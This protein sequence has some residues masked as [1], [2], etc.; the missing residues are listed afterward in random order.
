METETAAPGEK[1][2]FLGV[3]ENRS[4]L[5]MRQYGGYRFLSCTYPG[6]PMLSFSSWLILYSRQNVLL[7]VPMVAAASLEAGPYRYSPKV[8]IATNCPGLK[9]WILVHAAS[10]F[11][12]LALSVFL[13]FLIKNQAGLWTWIL[14]AF[15]LTSWQKFKNMI[16]SQSQS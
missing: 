13:I 11:H 7:N 16:L 12:F 14:H 6:W 1:P 15:L 8:V 10:S 5:E 2:R 9:G 3:R 4:S